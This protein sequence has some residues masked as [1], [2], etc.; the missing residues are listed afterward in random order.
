MH[1]VS[2]RCNKKWTRFGSVTALQIDRNYSTMT[3]TLFLITLDKQLLSKGALETAF[4]PTN[5]GN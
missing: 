5:S 3:P 4:I 1:I 2:N